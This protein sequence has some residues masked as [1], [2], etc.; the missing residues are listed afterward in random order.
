ME[1]LELLTAFFSVISVC[2]LI[3]AFTV[4]LMIKLK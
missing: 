2:F 1:Q 4:V 3:V